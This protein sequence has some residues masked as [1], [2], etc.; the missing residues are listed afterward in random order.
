MS[1]TEEERTCPRCGV[2]TT[3]LELGQGDSTYRAHYC[4]ACDALIVADDQPARP[5]PQP[6]RA[7]FPRCSADRADL[8]D[9]L[10]GAAR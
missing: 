5:V 2:V 3:A 7:D 1:R 10:A 6:A 4:D 8:E 9:T